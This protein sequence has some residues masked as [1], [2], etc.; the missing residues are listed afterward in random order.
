MLERAALEVRC[1]AREGRLEVLGGAGGKR[2]FHVPEDVTLV[3]CR[4]DRVRYFPQG[5]SSGLELLLRDRRGRERR[6]AVGAFTGL[7]DIS[8]SP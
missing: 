6:I 4:P 7:S 1:V 2:D 5:S 8:A 3:S